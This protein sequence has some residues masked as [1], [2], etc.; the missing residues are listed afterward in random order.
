MLR[1]PREEERAIGRRPDDLERGLESDA[2]FEPSTHARMFERQPRGKPG[3]IPFE[4]SE[5]LTVCRLAEKELVERF[6][7][8]RRRVATVRGDVEIDEARRELDRRSRRRL[9][10]GDVVKLLRGRSIQREVAR[11]L[12]TARVAVQDHRAR[13]CRARDRR[14][15]F[16]TREQTV[17]ARLRTHHARF[18]PRKLR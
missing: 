1:E 11:L 14:A 15:T 4:R 8:Q 13:P 12:V 17:L 16:R 9:P 7:L 2:R 3:A 10:V 5:V 6:V 18:I